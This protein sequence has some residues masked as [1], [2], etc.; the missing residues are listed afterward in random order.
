[1]CHGYLGLRLPSQ[2]CSITLKRSFVSDMRSYKESSASS[3]AVA[4]FLLLFSLDFLDSEPKDAFTIGTV[5]S[6]LRTCSHRRPSL[7]CLG[8]FTSYL[9]SLQLLEADLHSVN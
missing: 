9:C 5:E 2:S 4:V 1:M 6:D 7:R 8:L 3:A